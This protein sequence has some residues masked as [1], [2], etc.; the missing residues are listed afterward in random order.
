MNSLGCNPPHQKLFLNVKD[1]SIINRDLLSKPGL[2]ISLKSTLSGYD[3]IAQILSSKFNI[4]YEIT[5]LILFYIPIQELRY[6]YRATFEQLR[7]HVKKF[8]FDGFRD[9]LIKIGCYKVS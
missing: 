3:Q 8:G 5:C 9:E 7:H 6:R 4:P 2:K 1:F